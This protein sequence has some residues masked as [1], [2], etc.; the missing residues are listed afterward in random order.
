M[1][2]QTINYA[3]LAGFLEAEL[4]SLAYDE[5]FASLNNGS[6]R[7]EYV[8]KLISNA[9]KAAVEYTAKVG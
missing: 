6:D 5:T 7:R 1:N 9:N 4:K 8:T 3:Y 2:N